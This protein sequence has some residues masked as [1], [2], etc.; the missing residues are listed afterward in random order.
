MLSAGTRTHCFMDSDGTSAAS[1]QLESLGRHGLGA[2][3]LLTLA[4]FPLGGG[5]KQ[6]DETQTPMLTDGDGDVAI[7]EVQVTASQGL[8]MV[9][10]GVDATVRKVLTLSKTH[11]SAQSQVCPPNSQSTVGHRT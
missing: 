7:E 1:V 6:G 2:G 3:W 10:R 5:E 8:A 11:K 4:E 9:L